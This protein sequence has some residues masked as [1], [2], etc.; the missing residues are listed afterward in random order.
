[1]SQVGARVRA[2]IECVIAHYMLVARISNRKSKQIMGSAP[3]EVFE[4]FSG[5]YDGYRRIY[6][7]VVVE[8][9]SSR[10]RQARGPR[11]GSPSRSSSSSVKTRERV[12]KR[13]PS[14]A[15]SEKPA[16]RPGTASSVR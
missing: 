7:A 11:I 3:F 15:S 10:R 9:S 6:E 4:A 5:L 8:Y 2:K 14:G 16:P 13:I 12:K 1:M